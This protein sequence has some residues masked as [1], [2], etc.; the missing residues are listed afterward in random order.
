MPLGAKLD[1]GSIA[2]G[3]ALLVTDA[4]KKAAAD[5]MDEDRLKAALG[6]LTPSPADSPPSETSEQPDATLPTDNTA[7]PSTD[8]GILFNL[9]MYLYL[10]SYIAL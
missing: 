6:L 5:L 1:D 4:A 7:S 8:S 9:Y 3:A 10:C 2:V